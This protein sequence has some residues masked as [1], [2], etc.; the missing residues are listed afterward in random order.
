MERS[1]WTLKLY[2]LESENYRQINSDSE[3]CGVVDLKIWIYEKIYF[4][5]KSYREIDLDFE[6]CGP[7]DLD[8]K[9]Y[10]WSD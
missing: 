6:N 7:I 10:I 1:I 8:I 5:V 2:D 3:N 9:N 4:N